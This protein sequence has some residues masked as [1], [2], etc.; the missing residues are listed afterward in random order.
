M[1]IEKRYIKKIARVFEALSIS[2]RLVDA[3]APAWCQKTGS[4]PPF[5]RACSRRGLNHHAGRFFYRVLDVH[6]P[7]YLV[8][9][10]V[11]PAW[12]MCSA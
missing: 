7:L 4:P 6:P 3:S 10:R 8:A 1:Y 5:P 2:L 9:P 12:K 11:R